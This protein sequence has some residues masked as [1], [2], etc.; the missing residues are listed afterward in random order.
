ME[1]F[2][3]MDANELT[4]QDSMKALYLLIIL[5]KKREG[6]SKGVACSVGI[7]HIIYMKK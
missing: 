3:P 6:K 5:V 2:I 1:T 7:K 4:K